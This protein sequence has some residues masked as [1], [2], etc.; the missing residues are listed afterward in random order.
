MVFG[1]EV[2]ETWLWGGA[3]EDTLL[4]GDDIDSRFDDWRLKS[5]DRSS[6]EPRLRN[7]WKDDDSCYAVENNVL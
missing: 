4:E 7:L 6:F 2:I 5:F 1:G 3:V